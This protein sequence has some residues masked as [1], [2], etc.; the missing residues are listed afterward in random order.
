MIIKG[1]LVSLLIS[2]ILLLLMLYTVIINYHFVIYS[3]TVES[4]KQKGT[5]HGLGISNYGNSTFPTNDSILIKI[6]TIFADHFASF[7]CPAQWAAT[8]SN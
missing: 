2:C 1:P 6:R 5:P 3:P 7:S 4:F 8:L